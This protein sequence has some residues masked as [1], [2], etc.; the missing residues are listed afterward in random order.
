M[1]KLVTFILL[2]IMT[3]SFGR[4]IVPIPI[5]HSS[6]NTNPKKIIAV[7]ITLNLICICVYLFKTLVWFLK[8]SETYFY[9]KVI[10]NEF[11]SI[12]TNINTICFIA[13]NFIALLSV[14]IN[15]IYK[16]L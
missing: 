3:T 7:F 13:T 16:L 10:W 1:K 14:I 2:F 4:V 11:G 9:K 15:L 6:C 12:F 5:H 8:G